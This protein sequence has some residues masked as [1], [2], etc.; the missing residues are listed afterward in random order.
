M[1]RGAVVL[2][3]TTPA[4][5]AGVPALDLARAHRAAERLWLFDGSAAWHGRLAALMEAAEAAGVRI[6]PAGAAQPA[7]WPAALRTEGGPWAILAA[8]AAERGRDALAAFEAA[9]NEASR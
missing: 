6:L 1:S 8:R 4:A 2:D 5:W 9:I 7:D 3:L